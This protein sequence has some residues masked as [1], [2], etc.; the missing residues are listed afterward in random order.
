MPG[1]VDYVS[2]SDLPYYQQHPES[3]LIGPVFKDEELF[4]TQK[5]YHVGQMIGIV[6]A[7]TEAI[8]KEAAKKV[9]VKYEKSD[10]I[11]SIEASFFMIHPTASYREAIF[12]CPR[13]KNQNGCFSFTRLCIG[14]LISRK[15]FCTRES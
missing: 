13:T 6:L 4:A 15:S 8:A 12:L 1:V 3:N 5:V 2:A 10:A 14:S 7:D 11:F 9:V